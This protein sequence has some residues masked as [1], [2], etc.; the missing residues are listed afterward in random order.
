MSLPRQLLLLV[1]LLLAAPAAT[2][3][4]P[5]ITAEE[6]ALTSVPNDPN[7]PA[8]LR[9]DLAWFRREVFLR[10]KSYTPAAHAVMKR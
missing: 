8:P 2:A 10:E 6:R 9:E 5:E 4:F 3:G 1:P 7:A